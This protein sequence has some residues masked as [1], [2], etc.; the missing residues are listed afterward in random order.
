VAPLVVAA[1]GSA[2]AAEI[3]PVVELSVLQTD[4]LLLSSIDPQSE[5]IWQ[6]APSIRVTQEST[7][8]SADAIY[9]MEAFHYTDIGENEVY[10][11]FDGILSVGIL[12][13]RFLYNVGLSRTQAIK[14]PQSTIPPN[15]FV[16]STNRVDLDQY[17]VG[18]ELRFPLGQAVILGTSWTRTKYR[19]SEPVRTTDDYDYDDGSFA[20]DNYVAGRGFAWAVRY[21][22]QRAEYDVVGVPPYEYRQAAV[23]LG[24]WSSESTRWFVAGGKESAWDD[25]LDPS[26]EDSFWEVGFARTVAERLSAELAVGD[27]S[28]GSSGRAIVNYELARGNTEFSYTETPTTNSADRYLRGGLLDPTQ[29]P[30][31]L[32]SPDGVERFIAKRLQWSLGFEFDR[33]GVQFVVFDE[34]RE[35]RSQLDGAAL[36]DET[37]SGG[38]IA[39]TWRFGPRLSMTVGVLRADRDFA[40]LGASESSIDSISGDYLLGPRTTLTVRYELWEDRSTTGAG[41]NYEAEVV[42]ASVARTFG[43]K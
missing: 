16:L 42:T 31:Y 27:R 10:N 41:T 23:E 1:A 4:N 22:T 19:Y 17:F 39:F 36:S 8:I 3:E 40:E 20:I 5:T 26:L 38:N 33:A 6:L 29:P 9:E 14:D 37:Q 35:E 11:S 7:R 25:P 12:P 24:A 32:F 30:D 15:N 2:L 34:S 18:P 43:R 13:E 28:F 21:D